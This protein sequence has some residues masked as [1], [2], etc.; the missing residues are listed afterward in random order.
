[1]AKI[2]KLPEVMARSGLSRSSIYQYIQKNRFPNSVKIGLRSVG[3]LE[4]ELDEWISK[5][6]QQRGN[7]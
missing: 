2:L 7:V 5:C 6:S 4:D 3:W 1:M